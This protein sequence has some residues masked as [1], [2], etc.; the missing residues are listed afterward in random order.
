MIRHTKESLQQQRDQERKQALMKH[1]WRK[2]NFQKSHN[3]LRDLKEGI[4]SIKQE[5]EA[6]I[7]NKKGL[8]EVKTHESH[9]KKF[10]RGLKGTRGQESVNYISI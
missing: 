8:L 6:T 10:N 3:I 5:Q 9:N 4:T 1:R 2:G 7:I